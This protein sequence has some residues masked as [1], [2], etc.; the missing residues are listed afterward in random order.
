M[1]EAVE[2]S[3]EGSTQAPRVS[4]WTLGCR[5][6]QY[7]TAALRARLL[8]AG[9]TEALPA[10]GKAA[11]ANGCAAGEAEAEL[12]VVNTCTVTRRADQEARQL[13]RRL[14]RESPGSRILVT[15][16]YAQRAPE[17]LRA[18]PGVTAVLGAAEREDP[19]RLLRAAGGDAVAGPDIEV[20]PG[21]AA[22]AFGTEAPLHVGRSRALL[23]I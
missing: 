10:A 3:P 21:R 13:I 6:N 7:D 12:I 5:L 14:H 1:K 17:K 9:M 20:G 18:L 15:G 11:G 23:K 19:L 4:F 22:R 16:C 8:A 2:A